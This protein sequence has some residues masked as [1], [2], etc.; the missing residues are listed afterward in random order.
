MKQT[1]FWGGSATPCA[2]PPLRPSIFPIILFG[3]TKPGWLATPCTCNGLWKQATSAYRHRNLSTRT[4]ML[5]LVQQ[6]LLAKKP[7]K[8]SA[9]LHPRQ[10]NLLQ[11]NIFTELNK[12][13]LF[14]TQNRLET[15]WKKI[16]PFFQHASSS[17][18]ISMASAQRMNERES[19][20]WLS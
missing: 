5:A 3:S 18:K 8:M 1:T 4:R 10:G 16:C 2:F 19:H 7:S 15:S 20:R 14:T 9:H 12:T 13:S 6:T 11:R 17:A